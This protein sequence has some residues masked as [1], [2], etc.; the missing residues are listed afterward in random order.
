[1]SDARRPTRATTPTEPL[2]PPALHILLALV[3]TD[4]HGLGIADHVQMFTNGRITLGPGTL[5][6]AIKRLLELGFLEDAPERP[7]Q[8]Q[9]DPRRRYYHLTA[10]GRRAVEAEARAMAH[11]VDVARLKRVLR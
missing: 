1:M 4:R 2:T 3:D 9:D 7:K 10:R 8:G 5:Y 6:G 11:V